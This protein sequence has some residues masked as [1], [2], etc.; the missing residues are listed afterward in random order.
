MNGPKMKCLPPTRPT[1]RPFA[2]IDEQAIDHSIHT[3]GFWSTMRF[4][5]HVGVHAVRVYY[6]RIRSDVAT[7]NPGRIHLLT[8]RSPN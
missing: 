4:S 3:S 5:I 6:D 2:Q 8:C 1:L 7:A